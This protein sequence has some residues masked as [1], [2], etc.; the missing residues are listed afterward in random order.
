MVLVYAELKQ[1]RCPPAQSSRSQS[2]IQ[3]IVQRETSL[4]TGQSLAVQ[5]LC[6]SSHT[7]NNSIFVF[8]P[9]INGILKEE[10]EL[11]K[12]KKILLAY[13]SSVVFL[14]LSI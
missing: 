3:M 13:S 1:E 8:F 5:L 2:R 10:N 7:Q 9:L 12:G 11:D 14:D 4:E 6:P